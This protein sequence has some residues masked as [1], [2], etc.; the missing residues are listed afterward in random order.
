MGNVKV[1]VS[2]GKGPKFVLVVFY[3]GGSRYLEVP[4]PQ[5]FI[6]VNREPLARFIHILVS[7]TEVYDLPVTS[8]HVFYDLEGGLIAFNRNGSIFLNLRYYKQW[9]KSVGSLSLDVRFIFNRRHRG[10]EQQS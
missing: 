4:S 8:L 9:R 2:E 10:S 6:T 1:Y 7:L 3:N 5:A